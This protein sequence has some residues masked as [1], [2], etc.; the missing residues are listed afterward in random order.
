MSERITIT[1]ETANAAFDDRPA[2]EI[3]RILTDLAKDF[4]FCGGVAENIGNLRDVNGNT[5]GSVRVESI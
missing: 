1:I 3:A 5:C 4:K 2:S